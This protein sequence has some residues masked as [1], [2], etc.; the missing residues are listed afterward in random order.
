MGLGNLLLAQKH[1][2][3]A[4]EAYH[5]A[6]VMYETTAQGQA[7][8]AWYGIACAH[9][10]LGQTADALAALESAVA[11]GFNDTTFIEADSDVDA[12]RQH[13]QFKRVLG[14]ISR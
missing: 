1:F 8:K 4:I 6:R 11:A 12:I 14:Q 2:D 9:S 7:G 3:S 13:A 10:Q 5:Q